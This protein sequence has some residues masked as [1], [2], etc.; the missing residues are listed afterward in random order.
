MPQYF[1]E[2]P[3]TESCRRIVDYRMNGI[4][5]NFTTDTAVFSRSNVDFGTNLLISAMIEDIRKTGPHPGNFLDLGCGAGIVGIVMK[6]C[7]MGYNMFGTDI[8]SRAVDLATMNAA[9]N[10]VRV[11]FRQGDVLSAF[12][13]DIRFDIVATNPPVRAGKKTV[14]AFY[15]RSFEHMNQGAVIYVVLQRKQGAPSTYKKLS[16]LFGNCENIDVDGGY[17]VMRSCRL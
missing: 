7:F 6:S 2:Q 8:N 12:D 9:N 1:E 16:E 15:E 4:N 17:H 11:D 13:D 5:F 14:F 10:R 3:Q